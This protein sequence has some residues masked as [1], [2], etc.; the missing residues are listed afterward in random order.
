MELH[1]RGGRIGGCT[2]YCNVSMN[3]EQERRQLL[4]II[5]AKGVVLPPK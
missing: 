4:D 1:P 5:E 2:N 3:G